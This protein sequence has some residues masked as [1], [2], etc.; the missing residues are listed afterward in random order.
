M[1]REL[2]LQNR[3]MLLCF[4]IVIFLVLS[5]GLMQRTLGKYVQSHLVRDFAVAAKF[6][7]VLTV[8]DEFRA[9]QGKPSFDYRFLSPTDIKLLHF[10]AYNNGEVD[11]L[12]IPS[13]SSDIKHRIYLLEEEVTEFIIKAKETVCFQLLIGPEGLDTNEKDVQFFIDIQ[14]LE[15]GQMA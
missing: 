13:I 3:E 12:C 15:T 14:Q 4:L 10:Q 8:P 2:R 7:I 5:F 11:V 1:M 9:E 6:D